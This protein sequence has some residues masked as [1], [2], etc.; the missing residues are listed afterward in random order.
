MIQVNTDKANALSL[1]LISLPKYLLYLTYTLS[2]TAAG[3]IKSIQLSKKNLIMENNWPDTQMH[4][5]ERVG[6]KVSCCQLAT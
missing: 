5:M 4:M 1:F 2:H 6:G 3:C